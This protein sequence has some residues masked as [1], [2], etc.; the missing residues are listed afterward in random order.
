MKSGKKVRV[1]LDLS[2]EYY[3]R[4]EK[5]EVLA[6]AESKAS[7]IRDALLLYEQVAMRILK[8]CKLQTIDTK[9]E[10]E[11]LVVLGPF[12]NLSCK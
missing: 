11:T 6:G 1:T 10:A 9:G 5:L 2:A 4:L 7:L 8:G 12:C 3:S